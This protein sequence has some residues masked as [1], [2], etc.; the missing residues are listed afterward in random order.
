MFLFHL[1]T[2]IWFWIY[3]YVS[4]SVK[5]IT[6]HVW[7][8]VP[9]SSRKKILFVDINVDRKDSARN[10]K[11]CSIS[12]IQWPKMSFHLCAN[13]F[14]HETWL[15]VT[16]KS[17]CISPSCYKCANCRHFSSKSLKYFSCF[18]WFILKLFNNL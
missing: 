6:L 17:Q 7:V 5:F 4:C 1:F 2:I 3:L 9:K 16:L 13:Y 15:V 18:C 10:I 11:R 12:K 8:A 14:S